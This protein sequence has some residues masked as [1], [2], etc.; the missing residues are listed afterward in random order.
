M[1][2]GSV[3]FNPGKLNSKIVR[4][5]G[6]TDPELGILLVREGKPARTVA[7]VANFALHLDTTG[8]TEYSADYAFY[9]EQALQDHFGSKFISLFATGTCGDINHINVST[10]SPQKG[11]EE[12]Q[13]IGTTLAARFTASLANI[14]PLER[15]S[16][17][18]ASLVTNVP[19]QDFSAEQIAQARQRMPLVGT[20]KLSFLDQVQAYKVLD[21]QEMRARV[22]ARLPME[23]QAF[24]LDRET[25]L[26]GLPGEVF[27]E[28]GLAIKQASPFKNTFLIE[29]CNDDIGYVPTKKAFGEGSYE[30]VN[31][32]VQPGGGEALVQAA[33]RLLNSL[34]R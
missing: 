22:G 19:L 31:S 10:D 14:G 4:P 23:V 16:L 33:S 32:R 12:A 25:V 11:G 9:L 13:R 30:V 20:S 3:V 6:P 18:V 28:L 21:V 7:S 24:R 29:L 15:P 27:V 17:A 34:K 1:K 2:D 26:V 8:G 5:A